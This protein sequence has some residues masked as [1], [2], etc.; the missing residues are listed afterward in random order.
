MYRE[1]LDLHPAGGLQHFGYRP[2]DYNIA[3]ERALA[4][5][6]TWWLGGRVNETV[7]FAYLRPPAE[8]SG[9]VFPAE[10][11]GSG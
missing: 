8:C 2:A 5:G 4:A 10:I 6:W 1:Y 11:S 9:L 7:R 3:L